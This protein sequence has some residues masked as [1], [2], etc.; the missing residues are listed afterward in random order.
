MVSAF[1]PRT[2]VLF[3]GDLTAFLAALWLSLFLRSLE[4]PPQWF[5]LAHLYPFALLFVVWLGVFFIAGLYENRSIILARRALSATL[6]IAQSINVALAALF[7]FFVPLFGI[8]PKTVLFIYLAVSFLLI[9]VWRAALF[10]LLRAQEPA[11]VVGDSE[12]TREL[13]RGLRHAHRAPTRIAEVIDPGTPELSQAIARAIEAHEARVVIADWSDERVA[14]AVPEL[15][16]LLFA[17]IRFFD[18]TALYE[19]VFGRIALRHLSDSWIARNL[20]LYSHVFYD[21]LKRFMDIIAALL[22]GVVSLILFP[23]LALLIKL[24][25]GGSVLYSTVRIGQKNR[26]FHMYKFRSMS[27]TDAGSE[28]LKSKLV[29]TPIGRIM[30]A[31][32]LDEL[33]QVWNVLKGDLSLIGPRP[34]LPALVAEYSKRIPYYNVRHLVK[35]GLSGWARLYHTND[36]HH[37]A[38]V[39]ATREKLSYDLYYIKHRSFVLDLTIALKTIKKLLTR[40]G[41]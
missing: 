38:E 14:G 7:F 34:E 40:S 9:L 31:I 21:T 32:H 23:F 1:R 17:G 39:E 8:A 6:L 16:K 19:E 27:G 35:P 2:L 24:H 22:L 28:V 5:F 4:A 41:I 29:V 26:P 33:P 10:P 11:V 30:R 25:D 20:S 12:E 15:S 18:T 3:V 13:V 36:P 37:G